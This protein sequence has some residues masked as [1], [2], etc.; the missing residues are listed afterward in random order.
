MSLGKIL[1]NLGEQE[2]RGRNESTQTTEQLKPEY[3]EEF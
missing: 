3:L 2:L 1:E